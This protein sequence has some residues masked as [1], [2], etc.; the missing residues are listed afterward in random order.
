MEKEKYETKYIRELIE[1]YVSYGQA[2]IEEIYVGIG[3][4]LGLSEKEAYKL[5]EKNPNKLEKARFFEFIFNKFKSIFKHKPEKFRPKKNLIPLKD[6]PLTPDQWDKFNSNLDKYWKNE[7]D[8][9]TGDLSTKGF[10][11][12]KETTNFKQKKKPYK[13]K[14]L[15]QV[16]KD[17]FKGDMPD[18]IE[19]AY[20][21]YD[22]TNSEK[23]IINKSLS[24]VSMYVTQTNNEIKESIRKIVNKGIEDGKTSVQI[25]SNLYWNVEKDKNLTNKYTAETLKHNWNRIAAT[26]L[27]YVYEAGVLAPYESQAMESMENPEKTVYFVRTGGTCDW[28]ESK[29]GTLTRMVPADIITDSKNESLKEMGIHDPNTDIAIWFGKNNVGLK[30]KD[31]LIA[32]P[33]HPY[34]VATFTPIDLKEEFY[35]P[36]TGEV[37]KR[38]KKEKFVPQIKQEEKAK[39]FRKP[40]FIGDNLVRVGMNVYEAVDPDEYNKKLEIS[41]KNPTVPIPVNKNSPAYSRIFEAAQ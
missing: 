17:Q 31:W 37:E 16:V 23:K 24:N 13:N 27:A 22:F 35:N 20:R 21:K 36:K 29:Q 30:Q 1:Y 5:A 7:A 19:K 41:R 10:L 11:L 39:D 8:K 12:G 38:Q 3:I 32:C 6:S 2:I 9:I 34:N 4:A 40:T 25:A 28:C 33:A 14:S 26:E 15:Y 18:T